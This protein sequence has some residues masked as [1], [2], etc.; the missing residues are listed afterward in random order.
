MFLSLISW[1][2]YRRV[3]STSAQDLTSHSILYPQSSCPQYRKVV[4]TSTRA[5]FWRE[6]GQGRTGRRPYLPY[7]RPKTSASPSPPQSTINASTPSGDLRQNTIWSTW[8]EF[9]CRLQSADARPEALEK[10]GVNRDGNSERRSERRF[11]VALL[12]RAF[13]PCCKSPGHASMEFDGRPSHMTN[14][15]P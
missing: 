3:N 13:L 11:G 15:R 1:P 10:R 14:T 5:T 7:V 6:T 9:H 2:Q 8:E 12:N 4:S